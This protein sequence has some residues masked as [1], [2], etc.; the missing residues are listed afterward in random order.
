MRQ[1]AV[2]AAAKMLEAQ[3]RFW[4]YRQAQWAKK[5]WLSKVLWILFN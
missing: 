2:D 1:T 5:S 4:A 3:D